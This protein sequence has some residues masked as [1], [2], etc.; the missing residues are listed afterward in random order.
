ML[1]TDSVVHDRASTLPHPDY[2]SVEFPAI[3][4]GELAVIDRKV[5]QGIIG[6][7]IL[8]SRLFI[9]LAGK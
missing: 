4:A 7:L 6:K 8:S 9:L 3:E 2:P 1:I 5:G